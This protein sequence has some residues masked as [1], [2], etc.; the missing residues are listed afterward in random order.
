MMSFFEVI[1]FL[2]RLISEWITAILRLLLITPYHGTIIRTGITCK[3]IPCYV[4]DSACRWF[5]VKKAKIF[6]SYV[7]HF[8][9]PTCV[10]KC[11]ILTGLCNNL[12]WI[13]QQYFLTN[14]IKQS[15][16]QLLFLSFKTNYRY[17]L[18]IS[19]N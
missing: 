16:Y 7:K 4:H 10:R 13:A 17:N 8:W 12:F 6:W 15:Y 5:I 18:S 19:R 3:K 14:I 2:I 1:T 11:R 9:V